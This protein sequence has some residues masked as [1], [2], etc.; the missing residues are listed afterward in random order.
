MQDKI[1]QLQAVNPQLQIRPITDPVYL[2]YGQVLAD[3]DTREI[4]ARAQALVPPT[5]AVV[6]EPAVPALEV[7]AEINERIEKEVFGGM[8]VQVGW[9]YGRNLRMAGLEYHKGSE[10]NVALTDM[11]LL[12]GSELDIVRGETISYP[13]R[14]AEAFFVPAGMAFEM[15]PWC[16]HYA[17]LQTT[18]DGSFATL[19]YLPRGTNYPLPYTVKPQGEN[20][21]LYAVNKW[22]LIH[23][24]QTEEVAKG[25]YPG[26][27]G[28]DIVLVPLA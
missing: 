6:Y 7:Y 5:D 23:P 18:R 8:P 28:D 1:R 3:Y 24:D 13:T 10:V 19:V 15:A 25:A 20:R 21:L 9:C 16:L 4:V 26:L 27:D 2:R 22:L 14:L 12:L 11:I 17:P